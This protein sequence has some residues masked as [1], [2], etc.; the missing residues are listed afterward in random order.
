ML[1]HL[2][3]FSNYN[4]LNDMHKY[5]CVKGLGRC[6]SNY[7]NISGFLQ[8]LCISVQFG[9]VLGF[10]FPKWNSETRSVWV[11]HIGGSIQIHTH[12]KLNGSD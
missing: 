2:Y 8:L 7:W 12:R 6:Y 10:D 4:F 5:E 1:I 11:V 9:L 3:S